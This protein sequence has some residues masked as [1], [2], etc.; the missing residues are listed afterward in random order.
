LK[1]NFLKPQTPSLSATSQNW[2]RD[3]QLEMISQVLACFET[4]LILNVTKCVGTF[5]HFAMESRES[6]DLGASVPTLSPSWPALLQGSV[7]LQASG[8]QD[9]E[10]SGAEL[11]LT[12]VKFEASPASLNLN[13]SNTP[14]I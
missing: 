9:H 4:N 1:R 7:N 5:E 8:R 14:L 10:K 11:P 12:A 2:G 6:F 13:F 3:F